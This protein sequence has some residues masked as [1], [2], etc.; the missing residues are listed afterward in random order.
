M[1]TAP[2][3]HCP[4]CVRSFDEDA[5]VRVHLT[6]THQLYDLQRFRATRPIETHIEPEPDIWTLLGIDGD[7][8]GPPQTG[9]R[10]GAYVAIAAGFLLILAALLPR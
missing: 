9:S 6:E 3:Y 1:P 5:G 10:V 8:V 7:E 4:L 2:G